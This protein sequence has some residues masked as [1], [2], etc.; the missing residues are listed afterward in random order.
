VRN[1]HLKW[2]IVHTSTAEEATYAY[3]ATAR[4]VLG[5]WAMPNFPNPAARPARAT[6][7]TTEATALEDLTQAGTL[8]NLAC[9]NS[10]RHFVLMCPFPT[11]QGHG[12]SGGGSRHEVRAA[13]RQ[14]VSSGAAAGRRALRG[15]R[16]GEK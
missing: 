15:L 1:H 3:D 9:A 16:I 14:E 8:R 11:G 13:A 10:R 2:W 4:R 6:V 7:P 5:R 12:R